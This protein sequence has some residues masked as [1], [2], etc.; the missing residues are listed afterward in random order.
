MVL[1]NLGG[2][3]YQLINSLPPTELYAGATVNGVPLD[4]VA[5]ILL[6]LH[7][8][9]AQQDIVTQLNAMAE[10]T[11]FRREGQEGINSTLTRF[12]VIR[13]RAATE[14]QFVMSHEGYAAKLMFQRRLTDAQ[15]EQLLLPYGGDFP[16]NED[17]FQQLVQGIRRIGLL[18]DKTPGTLGSLSPRRTPPDVPH[19]W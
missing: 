18:R 16:R 8:R 4:P 15:I 6:K 10:M 2:A 14:G 19:K 11:E 5:N 1:M 13:N 9:F 12:E 17:Q 3:A 7:H